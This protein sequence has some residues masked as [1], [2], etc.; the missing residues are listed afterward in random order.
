MGPLPSE[1]NI[2]FTV[3]MVEDSTTSAFTELIK[4]F[5]VYGPSFLNKWISFYFEN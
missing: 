1:L 4:R 5:V 2:L 3:L